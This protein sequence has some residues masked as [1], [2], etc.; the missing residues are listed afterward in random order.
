MALGTGFG[1]LRRR[2]AAFAAAAL[3]ASLALTAGFAAFSA[4]FARFFGSKL[5]GISA[6]VSLAACHAGFLGIELVGVSALMGGTATLTRDFTLLLFIHCGEAP[7][8]A[9]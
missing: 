8:G 5:V 4:G 7:W 9:A 6:L 1:M 3:G 2:T